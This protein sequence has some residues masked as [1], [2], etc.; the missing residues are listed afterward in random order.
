VDD[1]DTE[2]HQPVIASCGAPFLFAA[3]KEQDALAAAKPRADVF[4]RHLPRDRVTG[5][6][7][8]TR[9]ILQEVDIQARMF[10]PLH[11]IVEDPATGGA[12][13]ALIGLLA[14]LDA[15]PGASIERIIGQG[16]AMGRPSQLAALAEKNADG[17]ITTYIGGAC[18]PVMRGTFD[19][20]V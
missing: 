3:L 12:N 9:A 16:Y 14:H 1:I 4:E 11:G 5:I 13:V 6:H 10:A 7:L 8:Y 18:V 15:E 19:L 17:T 2:D 20:A